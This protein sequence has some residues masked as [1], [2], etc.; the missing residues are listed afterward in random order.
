MFRPASN[1]CTWARAGATSLRHMNAYRH[2]IGFNACSTQVRQ[3]HGSS[4]KKT[5]KNINMDAK[6]QEYDK[7]YAMVGG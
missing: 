1:V 5:Q 3:D 2:G 7:T 6:L 4:A